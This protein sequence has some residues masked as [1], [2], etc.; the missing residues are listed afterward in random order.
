MKYLEYLKLMAIL[1][2]TSENISNMFNA[3]IFG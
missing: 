2:P 3:Y 1:Y